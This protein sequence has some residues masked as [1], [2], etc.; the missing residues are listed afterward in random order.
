MQPDGRHAGLVSGGCLEGDLIDHAR[1]ICASGKPELVTYD[2]RDDAD[3][4]WGIGLGC[5]GLMQLFLQRI[6]RDTDWQPFT[7]IA[8]ACE[9][10]APHSLSLITSSN[11]PA[12]AAGSVIVDAPAGHFEAGIKTLTWQIHPWPRLLILGAAPDA[13][14][15][16]TFAREL[17]WIVHVADHRAHYFDS[18]DFSVADTTTVIDPVRMSDELTPD[19]FTAV[20]VMSHHLETDRKYLEQLATCDCAYIGVLGPAAR[21]QKLLEQL[22]DAGTRLR[23]RLHGPVGLDIGSDTP[24]TIALALIAEIQSVLASQQSDTHD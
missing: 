2:M 16:A 15:V 4:L 21:K 17:G 9:D 24:E 6:G 18:T 7:D 11:D 22:G 20:I 3:D 1:R 23:G 10:P 8:R 12:H 13:L 14:P 19:E 5:N